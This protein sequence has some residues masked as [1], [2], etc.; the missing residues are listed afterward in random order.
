MT[1]GI[2]D[3]HQAVQPHVGRR[4]GSRRGLVHADRVVALLEH[5]LFGLGEGHQ[6]GVELAVD[7]S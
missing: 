4:R 5:R 1:V 2:D 3:L 7:G 6:G